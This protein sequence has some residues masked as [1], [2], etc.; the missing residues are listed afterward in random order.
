M[1]QMPGARGRWGVVMAAVKLA[2]RSLMPRDVHATAGGHRWRPADSGSSAATAPD[3][4][5]RNGR[6]GGGWDG[7]A[8]CDVRCARCVARW[9]RAGGHKPAGP[10]HSERP[11]KLHAQEPYPRQPLQRPFITPRIQ[12]LRERDR[13]LSIPA[14]IR[15]A[16]PGTMHHCGAPPGAASCAACS[17]AVHS[18]LAQGTARPRGT[19]R[20][21]ISLHEQ[22][23]RLQHVLWQGPDPLH[24]RPSPIAAHGPVVFPPRPNSTMAALYHMY[25]RRLLPVDHSSHSI[26][27]KR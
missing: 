3:G 20:N 4:C 9:P 26:Q 24:T 15:P 18:S 19:R 27:K 13:S 16:L 7:W 14:Y 17:E 21:T 23:H 22:C 2:G 8:M 5:A 25:Q 12:A 6:R 11:S 10:V 1:A